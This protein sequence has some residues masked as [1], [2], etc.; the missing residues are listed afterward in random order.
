MS[1]A[2]AFTLLFPGYVGKFPT[3]P[4]PVLTVVFFTDRYPGTRGVGDN[5]V[6]AEG[7]LE[8]KFVSYYTALPGSR[9]TSSEQ[10]AEFKSSGII[11]SWC[12]NSLL[13]SMGWVISPFGSAFSASFPSAVMEGIPWSAS[14][15]LFFPEVFKGEGI[16]EDA[17]VVGTVG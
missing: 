12:F 8:D 7:G 14:F 10:F 9:P 15:A 16:L 5:G 2:W 13:L 17:E 4:P 6:R 11:I 1:S 3:T